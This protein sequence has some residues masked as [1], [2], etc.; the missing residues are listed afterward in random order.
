MKYLRN[1]LIVLVMLIT[2]VFIVQNYEGFSQKFEIGLNLYIDAISFKTPPIRGWIIF[3]GSFFFG[4]VLASI[5]GL[6]ER[7]RLKGE[8]RQAKKEIDRLKEELN[9]LRN[10]PITEEPV[11]TKLMEEEPAEPPA[12]MQP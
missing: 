9:S 12:D 7:I 11:P 6:M 10:L 8:L 5:G 4:V 1:I 2:I 3:L